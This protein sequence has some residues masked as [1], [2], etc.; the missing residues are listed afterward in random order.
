[1][2]LSAVDDGYGWALNKEATRALRA[3]MAGS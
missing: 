3:E 2:V 1:V